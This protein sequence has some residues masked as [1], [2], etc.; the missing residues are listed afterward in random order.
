[1]FCIIYK[2]SERIIWTTGLS[3]I[4]QY[5]DTTFQSTFLHKTKYSILTQY[6]TSWYNFSNIS[7][8]ARQNIPSWHNIQ[9]PD[10]IFQTSLYQH[11]TAKDISDNS[12]IIYYLSYR[13]HFATTE[14]EAT[15]QKQTIFLQDNSKYF[16]RY[17]NFCMNVY[18][19]ETFQN[20]EYYL[21]WAQYHVFI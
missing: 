3:A 4:Q 8:S 13:P 7:I 1:M 10:T 18:F 14:L 19:L 5:A 17:I 21:N 9:L 15:L 12:V 11:S 6:S 16:F 20:Y 2:V